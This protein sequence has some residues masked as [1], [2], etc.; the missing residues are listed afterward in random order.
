MRSFVITLAFLLIGA[1]AAAAANKA[2][3]SFP[4]QQAVRKDII[5]DVSGRT[6]LYLIV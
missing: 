4:V 1:A 5:Q 3:A 2:A 6:P